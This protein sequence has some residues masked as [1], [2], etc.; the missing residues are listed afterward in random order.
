MR[1]AIPTADGMLA[2]HFGHAD[3]FTFVDVEDGKIQSTRSATPPGH[4]PGVLPAWLK[5]NDVGVII[6]GGMGQRAQGLFTEHGIK[7]VIGASAA[8]AAEL[9]KQHLAGALVTGDNLCDH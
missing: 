1:Y 6:A 8:T 5:E 7:V 2:M 4:A 3:A 9:V